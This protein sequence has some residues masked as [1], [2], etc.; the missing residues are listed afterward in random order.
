MKMRWR[1]GF[2]ASIGAFCEDL[3]TMNELLWAR[4]VEGGRDEG[5]RPEKYEEDKGGHSQ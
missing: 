1:P 3:G 5:R 4:I 2:G